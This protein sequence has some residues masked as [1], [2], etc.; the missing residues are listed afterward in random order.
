MAKKVIKKEPA[1]M[2][3]PREF[4]SPFDLQTRAEKYFKELDDNP[5]YKQEAIKSGEAAGQIIEIPTQRP[6]TLI[7]LCISMG[8]NSQYFKNFKKALKNENGEF[9]NETDKDFSLV[10]E[11]IEDIIYN[12]KFTGAVVGAFNANIIS[13][14]LGL[15]EKTESKNDNTN[16]NTNHNTNETF[17]KFEYTPPKPVDE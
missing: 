2:G 8:V 4:K 10:I 15:I 3:R 12:Q 16:T 5:W 9:K 11:A 14:D 13:R 1:L 6:Y 7:G 17:V